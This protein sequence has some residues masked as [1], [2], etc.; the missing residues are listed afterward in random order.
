VIF[1]MAFGN[2]VRNDVGL[3]FIIFL[4]PCLSDGFVMEYLKQ[5]RFLMLKT[6]ERYDVREN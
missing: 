4:S 3:W 5:G 1:S 2:E 6:Y